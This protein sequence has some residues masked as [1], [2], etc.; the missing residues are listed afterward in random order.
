MTWDGLIVLLGMDVREISDD[1]VVFPMQSHSDT[2]HL[3]F[4]FLL[5]PVRLS[6]QPRMMIKYYP[7]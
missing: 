4:V 3:T 2:I 7:R 6:T 1:V 5:R